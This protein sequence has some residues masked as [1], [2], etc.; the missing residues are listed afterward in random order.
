[1]KRYL[2]P[3]VIAQIGRLDLVARMVVEGT[4]A[5]EHKSRYHGF[6]IEF[7]EHRQYFPG[8]ELRHIDWKLYAKSDRYYVKQYEENT[9]LRAHI[10]LDCSNSMAYPEDAA[11]GMSKLMYARYL[12]ASLAYL[13]LHQRDS[14]GVVTFS[15]RVRKLVPPRSNPAHLQ[16]VLAAM[17]ADEPADR[18]DFFRIFQEFAGHVK[19]RGLVI[20]LSDLF[21]DPERLM[22]GV[23]YL[24]FLKHEVILMHILTPQE[25]DFP[26]EDF[27]NFIDLEDGSSLHVDPHIVRERYRHAMDAYVRRIG[28][29]ARFHHV[30][31]ALFRTD[32]PFEKSLAR[33]LSLRARRAD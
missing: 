32:Q 31:Y 33:F 14:V 26:F 17:D 13:A 30:D 23:K 6:N 9:S 12:A 16:R 24:K 29:E 10:L 21:D 3:S 7:A 11:G 25:L 4:L 18:T 5:G 1:M 8:D 2:S 27:T 22:Q 28:Q 19:R 15:D 20:D